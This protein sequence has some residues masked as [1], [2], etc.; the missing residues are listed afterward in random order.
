VKPSPEAGRLRRVL[1]P[2][3]RISEFLFGLIMVLTF[4]G[5]LSAAEAGRGEVRDMLIGALGCNL[6]WGIIDGIFY[7]MGCLAEKG[8]GLAVWRA[9][10]EAPTPEAAQR[11]IAL[12]LPDVAASVLGPRELEVMR[13]KLAESDCPPSRP[14]LS[15][16]EWLGAL[17]VFGWVFLVT[18]PVTIPFLFMQDVLRA[19]RFSNAI[20]LVLLFATGVA[21]GRYTQTRHPWLSGLTMMFVGMVLVTLT[22]ALG[23]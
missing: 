16:D 20:A 11:L 1:D 19:M 8:R 2:I 17:A 9:V 12:A 22:I 3:D 6:A 13:A 21:F 18:F 10:R 4:T 23:G 14:K 5:S 15:A 7:L